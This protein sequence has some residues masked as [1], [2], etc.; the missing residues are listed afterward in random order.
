MKEDPQQLFDLIKKHIIDPK[1]PKKI[2]IKLIELSNQSNK[3][4]RLF[5][6]SEDEMDRILN[7]A[8]QAQDL[9][10]IEKLKEKQSFSD[11][12]QD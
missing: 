4:T 6:I 9:D 5:T 11:D 1:E 8:R 7:I 12:D 2:E 3:K 10:L